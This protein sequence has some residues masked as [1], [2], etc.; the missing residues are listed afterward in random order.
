MHKGADCLQKGS[1]IQ[2]QLRLLFEE[3]KASQPPIIFFDKND[4]SGTSKQ[5]QSTR[6]S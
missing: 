4:G 5:D 6:P 3:A 1:R 2:L